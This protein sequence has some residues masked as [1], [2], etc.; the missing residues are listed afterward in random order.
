MHRTLS[1][2]SFSAAES[3]GPAVSCDEALHD[4]DESIQVLRAQR[5]L[6]KQRLDRIIDAIDCK[7]PEK[8]VHDVRNVLNELT[9]LRKLVELEDD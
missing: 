7:D 8:V 3:S 1:S 2:Q 4:E 6:Y 5:D 9:L